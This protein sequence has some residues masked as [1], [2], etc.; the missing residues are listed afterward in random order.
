MKDGWLVGRGVE[1]ADVEL[2]SHAQER[3]T[4]AVT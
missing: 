1:E 3:A 2:A 4:L